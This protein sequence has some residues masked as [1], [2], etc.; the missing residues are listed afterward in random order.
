MEPET[1]QILNEMQHQVADARRDLRER[2][3]YTA[4]AWKEF[5]AGANVDAGQLNESGQQAHGHRQS[6]H[7]G[8]EPLAGPQPKEW[9]RRTKP[10]ATWVYKT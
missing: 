8:P 9:Q 7:R 3:E 5:L 2:V 10:L 1:K 6:E 4:Q